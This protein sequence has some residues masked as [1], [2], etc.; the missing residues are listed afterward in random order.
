MT[1]RADSLVKSFNGVHA[2]DGATVE[3]KGSGITAIIGPNGA[4]KTTLVDV[5]TGFE[6]A[7][8]GRGF[9]GALDITRLPP[10]RI[11][12]LGIVR[13]FQ[14][15]RLV[16][17]ETV[18]ENVMLAIPSA[19]ESLW[20][21]ATAIRLRT[22]NE[23]I[24]SKALDALRVVGLHDRIEVLA[25]ELS[26]GQQKLLALARCMATDAHW[27]I[28]DEPVSGVSPAIVEGVLKTLRLLATDGRAI[29]LIEHDIAAVRQ[30]ADTVVVLDQ[31]RVVVAG[32]S[33]AVLSRDDVLDAYLG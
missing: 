16:W 10:D 1:L 18:L 26:Y 19:G 3:F 14:E 24:Q 7:D 32:P 31:G 8:S 29:L 28:L 21:A 22:E 6:R 11:S 2:L 17:R 13:T 23:R 27:L 12:R 9:L 5:L 33:E 25:M 20:R 30:V 15:V 4:G